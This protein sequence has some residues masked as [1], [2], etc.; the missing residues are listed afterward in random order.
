MS[1][2]GWMKSSGLRKVQCQKPAMAHGLGLS[3]V[4]PAISTEPIIAERG[5]GQ[6]TLGTKGRRSMPAAEWIKIRPRSDVRQDRFSTSLA[7]EHIRYAQGFLTVK[8]FM[9]QVYTLARGIQYYTAVK[10]KALNA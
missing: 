3:L 5:A 8:T 10:Y 2:T 9:H 6:L 7:P 4:Q 1:K